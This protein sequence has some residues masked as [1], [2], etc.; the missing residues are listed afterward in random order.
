MWYEVYTEPRLREK[1]KHYYKNCINHH[2]IPKLGDVK[3]NSGDP[4]LSTPIG[5]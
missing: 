3:L 1:T 4:S 2:I 5:S